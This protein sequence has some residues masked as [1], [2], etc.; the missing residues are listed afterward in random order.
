MCLGIPMEI[1]DV[2]GDDM[3]VAAAFG[4][5]RTIS[6]VLLPAPPKVGDWAMVHVGYA[7]ETLAYEEAMEILALLDAVAR[8]EAAWPTIDA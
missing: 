6:T 7:L 8:E 3:A 4:V 2:L 1:V 5:R